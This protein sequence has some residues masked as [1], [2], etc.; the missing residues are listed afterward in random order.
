[1]AYSPTPRPNPDIVKLEIR[2]INGKLIIDEYVNLGATAMATIQRKRTHFTQD[3]SSGKHRITSAH[4]LVD[5][6]LQ[7]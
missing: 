3:G 4:T 6:L 1:M 5:A 7:Q 2:P